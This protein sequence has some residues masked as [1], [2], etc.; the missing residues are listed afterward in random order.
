VRACPSGLR[1][2]WHRVCQSDNAYLSSAPAPLIPSCQDFGMPPCSISIRVASFNKFP[3]F[4][5][6]V[7]YEVT[8]ATSPQLTL[9]TVKSAATLKYTGGPAARSTK[10]LDGAAKP[11]RLKARARWPLSNVV[12]LQMDDGPFSLLSGGPG[13]CEGIARACAEFQS[14]L[15]P[16]TH[17][18]LGL[19]T[20]LIS[21][22]NTI[23]H[24]P[25]GALR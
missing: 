8:Q 1:R 11:P 22:H 3:Q 24:R 12:L 14:S 5:Q 7:T 23:T 19:S 6:V 20:Q 25:P 17:C 13:E 10:H 4:G 16:G 15:V 21:F 9:T 2:L 18:R